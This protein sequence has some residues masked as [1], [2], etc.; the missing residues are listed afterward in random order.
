MYQRQDGTFP[1][2]VHRPDTEWCNQ[3]S[4]DPNRARGMW[5]CTRAQGHDIPNSSDDLRHLAGTTAN[6]YVAEWDN[7]RS[8]D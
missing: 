2:A 1:G 7:D 6:R 5:V 4:P 3:R 8:T